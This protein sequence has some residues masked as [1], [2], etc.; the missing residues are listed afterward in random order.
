MKF[1]ATKKRK[2]VTRLKRMVK[3]VGGSRCVVPGAKFVARL[4]HNLS[5]QQELYD[6]R[7]NIFIAW[8]DKDEN[9]AIEFQTTCGNIFCCYPPHQKE[10]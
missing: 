9:T 8:Y 10:G 4:R 1:D 2:F 6:L 3:P 7:R 5:G